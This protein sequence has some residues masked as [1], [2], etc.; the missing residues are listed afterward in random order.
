MKLPEWPQHSGINKIHF[1]LER[2]KILLEKLDNPQNKI[3]PI[4]HIAGTNGKGSTSSFLKYILEEQGYK[5]HRYTSPHLVRFNERIEIAGKEISDEYYTELANKCKFIIEKYN[6]EASYFEIITAIAFIAFAENQADVTILEVGMGGRLD[7]T[8]IVTSPLVSIITP[9]SLDHVKILGN[10]IEKIAIEKLGI[11]KSNNNLILSKQEESVTELAIQKAKDLN[12]NLYIFD[13]NWSYK[14]YNNYCIFDNY[15]KK[16]QTPLPNLE[17]DHQ[18]I[19]CGTAIAALL[20]QN[21]LK[22]T[23]DAIK[24][25]VAKTFW[26]ARLQNLKDTELYNLAPNDSELYIDGGHNEGGA[27]VIKD[28][29]E[30]KQK[31]DARENILI[32]SMLERKDTKAYINILKNNFTKVVI[33]S[34][35]ETSSNNDKYKNANDFKKEFKEQG[36]NVIGTCE[37]ITQAFNIINNLDKK[38]NLRILICGSLYFCGDVLSLIENY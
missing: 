26:K 34:S 13:K 9:I 4:F 19:N 24:I 8:N 25:G 3:P 20:Y 10:T 36:I 11:L 28:W 6:I 18:I 12:C 5:V 35:N 14:K 17:G 16:I 27:R 23:D 29:I 22:I 31:I 15:S 2:I 7:A 21:K 1:G 32:I 38:N 37:N 33:V 30:N